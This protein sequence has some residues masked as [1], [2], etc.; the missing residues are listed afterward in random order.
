MK[1]AFALLLSLGLLLAFCPLSAS[2]EGETVVI[3]S[4]SDWEALA[5]NCVLDTWSLGKTIRLTDDL[6]FSGADFTPVP[7]LSGLF[8]GGGHTLSGIRLSDA[9]SVT[10]VFRQ[11]TAEGTVRDLKVSAEITPGGTAQ[12]VGGIAGLNRGTLSGCTFSGTVTGLRSVGGIC[13]LNEGHIGD[14]AASGFVSAQHRAGGIAGENSGDI[15]GCLNR[16]EV[17]TA[18]PGEVE[19]ELADLSLMAEELLDVTDIGGIAGLSSGLVTGC[20]NEGRVGYLRVGY[21][22]GGIV[23]RLSGVVSDCRSSGKVLGR[24]DVGG[25]VGQLDP[26]TGWLLTED[27]LAELREELE[28]LRADVSAFTVSVGEESGHLREETEQLLSALGRTGSAAETLMGTGTDWLN[29]NLGTVNELSDRIQ[30]LLQGLSETGG[31][32][33]DAFAA[34]PEALEFFAAAL[35]AAAEAADLAAPGAE[36]LSSAIEKVETDAAELSLAASTV[37]SG[38]SHLR[39]GIGAPEAIQTA[40]WELS[41]GLSD[42]SRGNRALHTDLQALLDMLRGDRE[43]LREFDI[44]SV[45]ADVSEIG[46]TA[47]GEELRELLRETLGRYL[48]AGSALLADLRGMDDGVGE[49]LSG[50]TDAAAL[51]NALELSLFVRQMESAVSL[52]GD[53]L[54][55][56]SPIGEDLRAALSAF[57]ESGGAVSQAALSLASASQA[58]ESVAGPMQDALT[59][60]RDLLGELGEL[61]T[62]NF[63]PLAS[64]DAAG[65]L[66]RSL[67]DANAALSAMSTGLD[68]GSPL[69]EL[70]GITDRFFG[71]FDI[72]FGALDGAEAEAETEFWEDI[73]A[74]DSGMT[75]IVTGCRNNAAVDAETNVGGVVGAISVDLSFDREDEYSLSDLLSGGAKYFISASLRNCVSTA[76][77]NARKSAAGGIVGRMDYGAVSGC[78]ASGTV[79]AA[80]SYIGGIAGYSAGHLEGCSARVSLRGE[81]YIGGIAGLGHDI[82]D[83]LAMPDFLVSG[84][85]QGS[86][87]GDADGTLSGNR[88]AGSVV[89]GINGFSFAGETEPADYEELLDLAGESDLFRSITVTFLAEGETVAELTVP[90]GGSIEELPT[91]PEKDGKRWRWEVFD[92]S[93]IYRSFAVTGSYERSIPTLS[94][95]GEPPIYLVEGDFREGQTLSAVT[96]SGAGEMPVCLTVSDYAGELTVRYRTSEKGRLALQNDD[97]SWTETDY[98]RD[99][100]YIVFTM[101]NGGRFSFEPAEQ[102]SR[103]PIYL[104]A[105][106]GAAVLIGGI[107]LGAR[108]RKRKKNDE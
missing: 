17:N 23:G 74:A 35:T 43:S 49:I 45:A 73:S 54:G 87:A 41:S 7:L 98:A 59:R 50:L 47:A 60:L 78:E 4:V 33:S 95:G 72:L 52:L 86:V 11:V 53:A 40:W 28:H 46:L 37:S 13:G 102:H 24:K 81:S 14:C 66:F 8:D 58:L 1:R 27:T 106:G 20:E 31:D 96:S 39:A 92:A 56:L 100:S 57:E 62:L 19:P 85:Y 69:Q 42:L 15:E 38:L 88:Y 77:V 76:S 97:G 6:D 84:E 36:A 26:E 89:G 101:P 2:A 65:E 64:G 99:G 25:I 18:D 75:A 79:T 22:V 90:F 105:A 3:A 61:P 91:V 5:E 67:E 30:V 82:R 48:D 16:A 12:T 55:D 29:E 80:G 93:A 34:L 107:A 68:E 108:A 21:N 70:E 32:L 51:P 83:C 9:A 94:F 63:V 104:G 44:Y 10:G 103:L 71:L